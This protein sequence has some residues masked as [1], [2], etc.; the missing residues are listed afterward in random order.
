MLVSNSKEVRF[1]ALGGRGTGWLATESTLRSA[2][3][4]LSRVR[5]PPSAPWPDGELGSLRLPCC[6]LAIQKPNLSFKA[7]ET[8]HSVTAVTVAFLDQWLANMS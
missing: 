2:G 4:L 8:A 3:T 7:P 5:V 6:G 1:K